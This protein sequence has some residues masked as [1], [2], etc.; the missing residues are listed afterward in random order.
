MALRLLLRIGVFLALVL[1]ICAAIFYGVPGNKKAYLAALNDKQARIDS[2]EAD[3]TPDLVLI[4]GSNVAFGINTRSLS[5]TFGM[6]AVNMALH[7]GLRYEYMIKQVMA[8]PTEGDVFLIFPEFSQLYEPLSTGTPIIYQSLEVYPRGYVFCHADNVYQ[9]SRLRATAFAEIVQLKVK[10]TLG[11]MIGMS[12]KNAYQRSV[13]NHYGDIW[14]DVTLTSRYRSDDKHMDRNA[15]K[16]PSDD[17][18]RLT[19]EFAAKAKANGARVLL[20]YPAIAEAKWDGD[21]ASTVNAYLAEHLVDVTIVND[22]AEYVYPNELYFDTKYHTTQAG[23]ERRTAQTIS[24][25]R[26]YLLPVSGQ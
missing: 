19:N 2:L 7:A 18:I 17:F 11:R 12:E 10:R 9:K 8:Y 3:A 15:G 16:N 22:P 1:A 25:L 21:V 23:R 20:I 26:P 5:D 6:P 14:T 24:D 13:F 4:G